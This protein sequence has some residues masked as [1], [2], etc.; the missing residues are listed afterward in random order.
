MKYGYA[1]DLPEI[2]KNTKKRIN[3]IS[4]KIRYFMEC[5]IMKEFH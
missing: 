4:I 5:N 2:K 1:N 3:N